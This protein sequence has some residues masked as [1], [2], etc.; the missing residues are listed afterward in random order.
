MSLSRL[1]ICLGLLLCVSST[2][3]QT[4]K[5]YCATDGAKLDVHL[6]GSTFED[7]SLQKLSKKNL[8]DF[9]AS[10][11]MGDRIRLYSHTSDGY[12]ISFDQCVPGCPNVGFMDQFFSSTCSATIAKRDSRSFERSFAIAVL[13]NYENP[14][15]GYDIFKSIQQLADVYGVSV[16][17]TK[18]YAVISMVPSGI[19]SNDR[20]GLNK[21]YRQGKEGMQFPASF[22]SVDLIGASSSTEIQE[23]W[24]DV[25]DEK[26][27]FNFVRF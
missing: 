14:A 23:F 13:K 17:D 24:N 25:L 26:V 21:L 7:E 3:A 15:G 19:K 18:I 9:K 10:F 27:K 22:P 2:F 4:I 11:K 12:S 1:V 8:T 20:K 5:K 16:D 6:F